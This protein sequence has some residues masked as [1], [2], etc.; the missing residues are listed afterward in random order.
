L[1]FGTKL[2]LF[3]IGL[4]N[5]LALTI[6]FVPQTMGTWNVV[7]ENQTIAKQSMYYINCHCANHSVKNYRSKKEEPTV[8]ITKPTIHVSKPLKSLNYP[9]YIME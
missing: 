5:I 2:Q 4:E 8:I 1:I 7:V 9:Y 6:H 3:K